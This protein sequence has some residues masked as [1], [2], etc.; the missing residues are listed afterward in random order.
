MGINESTPGITR[1]PLKTAYFDSATNTL[2]EK[3][4]D[5]ITLANFMGTLPVADLQTYLRE[6][7]DENATIYTS[8]YKTPFDSDTGIL[9]LDSNGGFLVDDLTSDVTHYFAVSEGLTWGNG[10]IVTEPVEL[11]NGTYL[12]ETYT[13]YS[14]TRSA[15]DY[16]FQFLPS[17]GSCIFLAEDPSSILT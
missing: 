4:E 8:S 3:P 11:G 15:S 13:A 5:P 14:L 6:V 7:W 2:Y 16:G 9:T 17:G 1:N 10:V 12:G